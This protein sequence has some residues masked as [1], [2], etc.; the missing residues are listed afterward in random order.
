MKPFF[1]W[2]EVDLSTIFIAIFVLCL[3]ILTYYLLFRITKKKEAQ[4]AYWRVIEKWLHKRRFTSEEIKTIKNWLI[5]LPNQELAEAASDKM[6]L[7]KILK[8]YI[9]ESQTMNPEQQLKML[10]KLAF[11][12]AAAREIHNI[13]EVYP[14]DYVSVDWQDHHFLGIVVKEENSRAAIRILK[15][16][17]PKH[18]EGQE[19]TLHFFR[20]FAGGFRISGKI[21]NILNGGLIFLGDGAQ[22]ELETTVSLPVALTVELSYGGYIGLDNKDT[23]DNFNP[24]KPIRVETIQIS[25]RGFVVNLEKEYLNWLGHSHIWEAKIALPV[26]NVSVQWIETKGYL[27]VLNKAKLQFLF[28]FL[29]IHKDDKEKLRKYLLRLLDKKLNP[30]PKKG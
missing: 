20:P 3:L 16:S 12:A 1:Q 30:P 21:E 26:D 14:G 4:E 25:S 27:G 5:A 7:N 13:E 15:G 11:H 29:E 28:R 24:P 8:S 17:L 23:L 19:A 2:P 9:I 22:K 6:T 10:E 18:A